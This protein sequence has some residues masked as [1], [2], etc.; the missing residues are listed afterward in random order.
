MT[1]APA[2]SSS[3]TAWA[4]SPGARAN[5]GHPA[6]VGSPAAS[7][8]SFTANGIPWS[9]ARGSPSV[10]SRS[11][12]CA[13]LITEIHAGAPAAAARARARPTTS[14]GSSAPRR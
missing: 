3:A 10:A 1:T 11:S 13:V 7:M 5:A 12:N 8:L 14:P 6:V 4:L 9:G 2:A